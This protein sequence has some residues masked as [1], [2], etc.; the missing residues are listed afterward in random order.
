MGIAC[1]SPI[2]VFQIRDDG[3]DLGAEFVLSCHDAGD[4]PVE[5]GDV[6]LLACIFGLHVSADRQHVIVLADILKR[7]DGGEMLNRFAFRIDIHDRGDV[8][9][10]K[11][12]LVADV[13][14][15]FRRVDEQHA[16]VVLRFPEHDDAGGD[17]GAEE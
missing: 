15:P 16:V 10:R 4:L 8:V 12:V 13:Y 5:F 17:G 11:L 6:N 2:S 14:K 1:R 3:V 7:G 9:G